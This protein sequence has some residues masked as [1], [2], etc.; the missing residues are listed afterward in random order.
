MYIIYALACMF[1]AQACKPLTPKFQGKTF[2]M[3]E[4]YSSNIFYFVLLYLSFKIFW[5]QSTKSIYLLMSH[6]SPSVKLHLA[7]SQELFVDLNCKTLVCFEA[8]LRHYVILPIN[9]SAYIFKTEKKSPQK[10]HFY[11]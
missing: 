1:T 9:I 10:Y 11:T 6:D 4:C 8:D 7:L 3:T 2:S 5:S